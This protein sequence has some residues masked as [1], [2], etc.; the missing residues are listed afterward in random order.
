MKRKEENAAFR[1]ALEGKD[2]PILT[3]DEKWPLLFGSE[4]M[5]AQI[6]KTARELDTL[7][8]KQHQVREKIKEVKRLKKKLLDEIMKLR[9][10]LMGREGDAKTEAI[11]DKQT[12]LINDCN[13]KIE[14]L[15]DQQIGLP[16]EIYQVNFRLMLQTMSFCYEYM[17]Q[18]TEQISAINA[19]I[20]DVRTELKKQL[21]R[22]QE[23]ELDNYNIYTYMHQIFGPEVIE[24]FDMKYDPEKWHPRIAQEG[25]IE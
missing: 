6:E 13:D 17:Q 12:S 1:T 4:G 20:S 14:M 22:K 18:S 2:I 24:L 3:L 11:L 10:R 16:R 7:L 23:S 25:E 21:I 5:P 9:G 19:W 8:D 15:E